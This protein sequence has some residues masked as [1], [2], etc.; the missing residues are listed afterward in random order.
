MSLGSD[1][2]I[3]NENEPLN[4]K[5]DDYNN[6]IK[7]VI[8]SGVIS[9]NDWL[10]QDKLL[11]SDGASDDWFG[12]SV[13]I[14]RDYAIIGAMRDDDNGAESGSAY[15]F[16]RTGTTWTQEAKLLASDGEFS[17]CFGFSVSISGNRV[18]IGALGDDTFIGSAYVF[19]RVD[20][21]PNIPVIGGPNS[22]KPGT[23]YDFTF[24]AVEPDG[25]DV[26]YIINWGDTTSNT[27]I[28][29][30]SGTNVTVSH[31]WATEG[32]YTIT[33][34]AEDEFGLIGPEATKTVTMPRSREVQQMLFYRLLEHFPILQKILN[35]IK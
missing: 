12:I 7:Q 35:L 20:H 34:K 21:P 30:P 10:E 11:A 18:V 17:D 16:K 1:V 25:D 31:T 15:I 3:T 24:N 22:G 4:L 33:A 13:S 26:R 5:K 32:E 8:E 28:F 23:S 9:N 27:T 29:A 19:S 6:L 2:K 14:D